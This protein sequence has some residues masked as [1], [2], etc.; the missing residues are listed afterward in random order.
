MASRRL[1][2][3]Q[4][5]RQSEASR[6]TKTRSGNERGI[7][8]LLG[9]GVRRARRR[10]AAS[11]AAPRRSG[12]TR[13]RA[14]TRALSARAALRCQ[15]SSGICC[16]ARTSAISGSGR[17]DSGVVGTADVACTGTLRRRPGDRG[18]GAAVAT[19]CGATGTGAT[20]GADGA[21]GVATTAGFAGR[22]STVDPGSG[23]R[24]RQSA[25]DDASTISA[26]ATAARPQ[27]HAPAPSR[28]GAASASATRVR[29]SDAAAAS[30]L[31]AVSDGS[32]ASTA[33][34]RSG[35][36]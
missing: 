2:R 8:V 24:L 19:R 28:P 7:T 9:R 35:R 27:R 6:A 34:S 31:T 3:P 29:R 33:A 36:G 14:R 11:R 16:T 21:G 13:R 18:A 32:T 22:R 25:S 10:S 30:S 5:R 4:R 20:G 15:A 26:A 1:L 23:A 12:R 17:D